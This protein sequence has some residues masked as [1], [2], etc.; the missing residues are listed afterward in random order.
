[1]GKTRKEKLVLAGADLVT[2]KEY[3]A[4]LIVFAEARL[5]TSKLSI[6]LEWFLDCKDGM[7]AI[8][9]NEWARAEASLKRALRLAK[10][11]WGPRCK[12]LNFMRY[13]LSVAY[14]AR[15]KTAAAE[16]CLECAVRDCI[17]AGGSPED[18]DAAEK[19]LALCREMTPYKPEA[20]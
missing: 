7:A 6:D 15:S 4:A 14:L 2:R 19:M 18:L 8:E 10:K 12:E 11:L 20:K 1:M 5:D 13:S 3:E 17:A 9:I 16:M